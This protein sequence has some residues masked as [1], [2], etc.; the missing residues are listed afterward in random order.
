VSLAAFGLILC[1]GSTLI[2]QPRPPSSCAATAHQ[3]LAQGEDVRCDANAAEKDRTIPATWIE[4]LIVVEKAKRQVRV[5]IRISNAIIA[6]PLHLWYV[7]FEGEVFIVETRFTHDA[8]FSFTT[9]TRNLDLTGSK[10]DA[11]A[12]FQGATFQGNV[13]LDATQFASAN[14]R[15]VH[16]EADFYAGDGQFSGDTVFHA[17]RFDRELNF[18]HRIWTGTANFMN[19][20][21]GE[22]ADFTGAIFQKQADFYN[23]YF[24]GG[25]E[26]RWVE[27][28]NKQED[29]TFTAAHFDRNLSF[30][31]AQFHGP[32]AF[33]STTAE[34]V[35]EFQGS[36]FYGRL[37]LD[38]A[39]FRAMEFRDQWMDDIP[40]DK[41]R[42]FHG[43]IDLR[44]LTYDRIKVAWPELLSQQSPY[45]RQPYAQLEESLRR[46]GEDSRADD[47]YLARRRAER[48]RMFGNGEIFHWFMDWL[49]KIVGNYG[50]FPWPLALWAAVL[51]GI[52]ALIFAL[53]NA[54]ERSEK[55]ELENPV[56]RMEGALQ[57]FGLALA[58]SLH[59]FLPIE[60]P[61][62]GDW[63]PSSCVVPVTLPLQGRCLV[64]RI[65]PSIYSTFF[66]RIA[67]A[68]LTGV[69]IAA[70]TGLLRRA[71][72]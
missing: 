31:D 56:V 2:A 26:F 6:G 13:D 25:A 49:Y 48:Q 45:D 18:E 30:R 24:R 60:V 61:L 10:F 4:D 72:P 33:S 28:Q 22:M 17:A 44:G 51:V 19:A 42:Q 5:P 16:A 21:V 43:P 34:T 54:L 70:V 20:A 64:L 1:A 15:N 14:F 67:G 39:H 36:R 7:S 8:D 66:L 46:I 55:K 57:G 52:G 32:V 35:G 27:F 65:R 40:K 38:E 53:P 11:G 68:I 58:V 23:T 3:K 59:Q 50:V 29:A 69:G 47:V 12:T 9:F 63:V 37:L 41:D 62:G 71:A